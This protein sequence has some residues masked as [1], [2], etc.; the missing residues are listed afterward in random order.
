[1]KMRT[2]IVM[3]ALIVTLLV[4]L[5]AG[6]FAKVALPVD[7]Q[8][9]LEGVPYRILVPEDWNGTLLVYAHGYNE[10][11]K[12]PLLAPLTADVDDLFG[13]GFALAAS[14]FAGSGWNV[15]EGMQ[16]TVAL[17]AAFRGM[18]GRPQRT[19]IWGRSMGG[20]MTLGLIEKFPGHYDGAVALCAPASGTPRRY[21]QALDIALAY[22]VAFGWPPAWGTPGDLRDDLDFKNEVYPHIMQRMT[23]AA[24]GGWEFIRRVNRIPPDTYY[25]GLNRVMPVYFATGVRAELESRAGGPVAENIGRVYTLTVEDKLELAGMGIDADALLER[26]NAMTIFTA[27]PNARNYVEHYVNPSGRINRPV[28]TLHTTGD[29][30]ATPNNESAYRATVEEQGNGGLLMQQFVSGGAHCTFTSEQNIAA[31]DAMKYWL[32]TRNHPDPLIFFNP[33]LGFD[34]SYVPLP[35]PW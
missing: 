25:V 23:S 12:P 14:R 2:L 6:Q 9:E 35:W 32:D 8:G 11:Q 19:I 26:M 24:K 3:F 17:T 20:L 27:D 1:M 22:D 33:A 21:D 16:N 7:L 28:L 18:V 29:A 15:K 13:R 10:G 4:P 30:L 31:I 34:L 5:S